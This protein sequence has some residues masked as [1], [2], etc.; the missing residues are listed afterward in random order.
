MAGAEATVNDDFLQI[1]RYKPRWINGTAAFREAHRSVLTALAGRTIAATFVLWDLQRDE[2]FTEGPVILVV[3]G[4]GPVE[5]CANKFDELSLTL[6]LIDIDQPVRWDWDEEPWHF[7]W[8]RDAIPILRRV[9][10]CQIRANN[11]PCVAS[12]H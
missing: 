2:H 6:G 3:D 11:P 7:E 10:G 12:V 1:P 9:V 5:V 4:L 8:R